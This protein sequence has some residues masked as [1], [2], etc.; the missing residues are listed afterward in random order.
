MAST[1]ISI[2]LLCLQEILAFFCCP[3]H[4]F[5]V[6]LSEHPVMSGTARKQ[7][8]ISIKHAVYK[9][10]AKAAASL[11][12]FQALIE[13]DTISFHIQPHKVIC[14]NCVL[15][16]HALFAGLGKGYI[17]KRRSKQQRNVCV[18]DV[19]IFW[20]ENT[21]DHGDSVGMAC[22]IIFSNAAK[23]ESMTP[24]RNTLL[25]IVFYFSCLF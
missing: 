8:Y 2:T 10:N 17:Q 4:L 25:F 7:N 5:L 16:H 15:K 23:P 3:C 6:F 14:Q 24:T 1:L 22:S 12:P 18:W 21:W 20:R 9:L 19:H 13:Y 11:L